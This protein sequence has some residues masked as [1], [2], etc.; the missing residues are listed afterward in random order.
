MSIQAILIA[1]RIK[2]QLFCSGPDER[3][4]RIKRFAMVLSLTL[5]LPTSL[6]SIASAQECSSCSDSK[7]VKVGF[8][9]SVCSAHDYTVSLNGT[10]VEGIGS[11]TANSW[12]TTSKAFTYLKTDVTY[13][14]TAGTDSCSTH[15]VFDLPPKYTLEINGVKTNTI[16]KAGSTKGSGDGTWNLVVRKC[17]NCDGE[18]ATSCDLDLDSINWSVSMG[19]LSDGRSAEALSILENAVSA[20]VYTPAAL[21]YS[22]PGQTI[23]VDVVRN[24][25]GSV[26]QIKATQAL[27]D[28]VVI[29]ASEYEVRFYRLADV[30]TKTA[31][32]YPVSNQPFTVWRIKNPDPTTT[33]RLQILKI[34]NG[35]TLE[36]NEYT[37]DVLSNT[38]SLNKGAGSMIKTL[39]IVH[40][41]PTTRIETTIVKENSGQIISKICADLPYVRL[42]RRVGEGSR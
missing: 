37:Q 23:E 27:A 13:Q 21:I 16:D 25:D 2:S 20:S 10:S 4:L 12:V 11:C 22:P 19:H 35:V 38:W 29:S 17:R 26:R 7:P 36:T 15:I 41:T 14:I 39:A 33:R 9:A 31:G 42:G 3:L 5:V 8:T 40:P 6:F 1:R 30:G 18:T 34:Q 28:V 32:I 24:G